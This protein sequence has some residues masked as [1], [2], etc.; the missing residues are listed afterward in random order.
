M[1]ICK[2]FR[3]P[4]GTTIDLVDDVHGEKPHLWLLHAVKTCFTLEERA[5]GTFQQGKTAHKTDRR[6]L[7]PVRVLYIKDCFRDKYKMKEIL[8]DEIFDSMNTSIGSDSR[9]I[10]LKLKNLKRNLFPSTK[11]P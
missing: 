11:S 3:K 4:D 5:K 7:D 6:L 8:N 2:P 10:V 9:G 1:L